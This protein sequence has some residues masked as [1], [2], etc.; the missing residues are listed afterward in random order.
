[1]PDSEYDPGRHGT[2]SFPL[3]S[4]PARQEVTGEGVGSAAGAPQVGIADGARVGLDDGFFE[5]ILGV[6][7]TVGGGLQLMPSIVENGLS[8]RSQLTLPGFGATKL[9]K[10]VHKRHFVDAPSLLKVPGA[11]ALHFPD[12]SYVPGAQGTQSVPYFGSV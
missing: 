12:S 11:Q 10:S 6:G 5:D 8:Q 4:Y 2:H 7:E 1:M 9:P 3:N